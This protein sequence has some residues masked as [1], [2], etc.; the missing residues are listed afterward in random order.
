MKTVFRIDRG[1]RAVKGRMKGAYERSGVIG[2]LGATFTTKKEEA[3]SPIIATILL[4]AI[5]V[6]LAA[7]LYLTLGHY[8]A[9]S[10][11]PMAGSLTSMDQTSTSIT[12]QLT[13]T[14]PTNMTNLPGVKMELFSTSG[15]PSTFSAL[16]AGTNDLTSTVTGLSGVT[17]YNP[18]SGVTNALMSGATIV[19]TGTAA[20]ISALSGETL[21]LS[22]T[23]S[24]GDISVV[25]P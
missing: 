20:D 9:G 15:V 18:A 24:S 8:G 17:I 5:T 3:V 21:Q 16:T 19:L 13:Y 4:V 6:V 10:A 23:G 14:A 12:V 7:T 22:Y 2:V 25:L 1:F 11:V